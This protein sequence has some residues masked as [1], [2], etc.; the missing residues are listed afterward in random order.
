MAYK[1]HLR[2]G[3]YLIDHKDHPVATN[4][5]SKEFEEFI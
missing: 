2:L 3:G 4:L 1:N 5:H